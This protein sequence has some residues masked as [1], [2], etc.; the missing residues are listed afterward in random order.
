LENEVKLTIK[1]LTN[2]LKNEDE[3]DQISIYKIKNPQNKDKEI[4]S[5]KNNNT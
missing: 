1:N 4:K 2:N 5:S 3:N